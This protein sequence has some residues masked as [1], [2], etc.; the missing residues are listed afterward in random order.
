MST[1]KKIVTVAK[2]AFDP[3]TMV[4]QSIGT[5]HGK[6]L[7]YFYE[8]WRALKL[9]EKQTREASTLRVMLLKKGINPD[10]AA[11][12]IRQQ[13]HLEYI[14]HWIFLVFIGYCTYGTIQANGAGVLLFLIVIGGLL[15]C[16]TT[17]AWRRDILARQYIYPIKSFIKVAL[18][19]PSLLRPKWLPKKWAP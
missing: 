9:E 14:L 5:E 18:I 15:C 19:N 3:I 10:V 4:K 2:I 8:Q 6:T 7:K 1:K 11:E 12:G 16:I 13:S 17:L